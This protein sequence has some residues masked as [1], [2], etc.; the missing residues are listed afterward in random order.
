MTR[1]APIRLGSPTESD[2]V[3]SKV[4]LEILFFKERFHNLRSSEVVVFPPV[5]SEDSVLVRNEGCIL[6][7]M[8]A[9]R[10]WINQR[11]KALVESG[12]V[13]IVGADI[14]ILGIVVWT[15]V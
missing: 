8:T 14:D 7:N 2:T 12:K 1:T 13:W 4:V 3:G 11:V 5:E 15:G 9:K 10:D 6:G